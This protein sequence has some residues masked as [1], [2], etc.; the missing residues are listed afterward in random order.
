MIWLAR[1]HKLLY[2]SQ[3]ESS[4]WALFGVVF[5]WFLDQFVHK[6]KILK[7]KYCQHFIF[8]WP[9]WGFCFVQLVWCH[10]VQPVDGIHVRFNL[11]GIIIKSGNTYSICNWHSVNVAVVCVVNY[12]QST[13]LQYFCTNCKSPVSNGASMDGHSYETPTASRLI[14]FSL[15]HSRHSNDPHSKFSDTAI[16]APLQLAANKTCEHDS[17]L[18]KVSAIFF[19]LELCVW[20]VWAI[21]PRNSYLLMCS[22]IYIRLG[23]TVNMPA[24]FLD[25]GPIH[26]LPSKFLKGKFANSKIFWGGNGIHSFIHTPLTFID[27]ES[28]ES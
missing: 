11:G 26:L 20:L 25:V 16:S 1:F 22:V 23:H 19:G 2:Q 27:L 3:R 6:P 21:L 4:S 10:R 13:V 15:S 12:V 17:W 28:T 18:S 24:S 14:L 8:Y 9:W 7:S 5:S